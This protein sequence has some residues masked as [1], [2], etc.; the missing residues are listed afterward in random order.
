MCECEK[1]DVGYKCCE[2]EGGMT[3][4]KGGVRDDFTP[5]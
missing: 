1:K 2:I 4:V 5:H 3:T